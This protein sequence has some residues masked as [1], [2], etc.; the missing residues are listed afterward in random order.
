MDNHIDPKVTAILRQLD[1]MQTSVIVVG[2]T[3]I[4][5][6]RASQSTIK[7]LRVENEML[8]AHVEMSHQSGRRDERVIDVTLM[9]MIVGWSLAAA[10]FITLMLQ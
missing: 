7:A 1:E 9:C 6:D 8:A 3:A 10:L 2:R 4:D 5:Q